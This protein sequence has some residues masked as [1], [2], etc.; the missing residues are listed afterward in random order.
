MGKKV[1]YKHER[2]GKRPVKNKSQQAICDGKYRNTIQKYG[3]LTRRGISAWLP[4][5]MV[6]P[7][8]RVTGPRCYQI[9]SVAIPVALARQR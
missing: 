6:H 8:V 9:Q 4:K 2:M 5:T 3:D 7:N 1:E